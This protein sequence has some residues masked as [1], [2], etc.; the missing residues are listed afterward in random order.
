MYK[1]TMAKML[2]AFGANAS[3]LCAAHSENKKHQALYNALPEQRKKE[4]YDNCPLQKQGSALDV[5]AAI[6][7]RAQTTS[8]EA[9]K[10]IHP[11]VPYKRK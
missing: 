5:V 6:E 7:E 11:I 8:P 1:S 9:H 3:I 4:I 10:H 2:M